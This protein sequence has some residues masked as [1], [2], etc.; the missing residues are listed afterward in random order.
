MLITV[1]PTIIIAITLYSL[2]KKNNYN[3]TTLTTNK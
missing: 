2:K 1:L 3:I